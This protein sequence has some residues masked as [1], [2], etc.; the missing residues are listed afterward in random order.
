MIWSARQDSNLRMTALEVPC[1]IHLGHWRNDW[2][3]RW[4]LNPHWDFSP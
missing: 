2:W 1:L 3:S 4:D